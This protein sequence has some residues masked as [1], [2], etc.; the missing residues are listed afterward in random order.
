MV[1]RIAGEERSR[2]DN[3]RGCICIRIGYSLYMA[4][5][6][7]TPAAPTPARLRVAL[8]ECRFATVKVGRVRLAFEKGRYFVTAG[9]TYRSTVSAAKAADLI[10]GLY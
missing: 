4:D 7:N 10:V 6:N 1:A 2:K 8:R 3:E 9:G 5:T